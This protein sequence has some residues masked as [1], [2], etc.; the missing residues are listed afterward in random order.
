M[1]SV[2]L[3][4]VG[5]LKERYFREAVEEYQKRLGA[6]CRFSLVELPEQR[7]PED[8]SPKEKETAL[9]REA[10]EIEQ[11]VPA[12]AVLCCFCV[13]GTMLSSEDLA[14][15][16]RDWQNGGK[17]KLC[18]VIG[19]SYGLAERLKR[20]AEARL[21]VSRMTFPHHLFRVMALEQLYRAFTIL[22]GKRYHK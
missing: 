4:C 18:F 12:G 13:E 22:D 6:F 9:D 16:L 2:T 19:G 21:S 20:R 7:L 3:I 1:R 8:P 11:R 5:K 10:A 15:R 14:L 17:S